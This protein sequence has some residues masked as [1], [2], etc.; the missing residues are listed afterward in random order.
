VLSSLSDVGG[1]P[2][3]PA[4][5][6]TGTLGVK[7][8]SYFC[9]SSLSPLRIDRIAKATDESSVPRRG[10]T[11]KSLYVSRASKSRRTSQSRHRAVAA[12]TRNGPGVHRNRGGLRATSVCQR[13][14]TQG[15]ASLRFCPLPSLC[16]LFVC[17][18]T[19]AAVQ[20]EAL[21]DTV[22]V[23]QNSGGHIPVWSQTRGVSSEVPCVRVSAPT[24][25]LRRSSPSA[26]AQGARGSTGAQGQRSTEAQGSAGAK[27]HR[28][29]TSTTARA[30]S[31]A[32]RRNGARGKL[33]QRENCFHSNT[34]RP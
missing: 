6:W 24:Q 33:W 3:P 8:F 25:L 16:K 2:A 9:F 10:R 1:W 29:V 19:F 22:K 20:A 15:S 14:P 34:A 21:T 27:E 4:H 5:P 11:C 30:L 13:A 12:H 17:Q 23:S 32:S 28:S 18:R 7:H 26:G 31:E